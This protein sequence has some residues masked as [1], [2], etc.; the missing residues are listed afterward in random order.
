MSDDELSPIER[1]KQQMNEAKD[2]GSS[3]ETTKAPEEKETTV[4][5][6]ASKKKAPAK[7]KP[8]KAAKPAKKKAA[9]K[10]PAADEAAPAKKPRVAKKKGTAK[11]AKSA[12][13]PAAKPAKKPAKKAAAKKA[14]AKKAAA[15]KAPAKKTS[16][17]P[18][19][20][21]GS[22]REMVRDRK[23]DGLTPIE[24]KIIKF[25]A[26]SDE[27]LSVVSI[28]RRMFG[29]D[30]PSEGENSFRTVRNALRFPVKYGMVDMVKDQRGLYRIGAAYKRSK[31][32]LTKL[33]ERYRDRVAKERKAS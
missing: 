17:P 18:V 32:N 12:A 33:A 20:A 21:T 14:P 16:K 25:I 19:K 23:G 3:G 31:G 5:S 1:L 2:D 27:P 10:K 28:G 11:A 13:K 22:T 4:K 26:D 29:Q 6:T 24:R 8:V 15:K 30:C 9:A 7:K